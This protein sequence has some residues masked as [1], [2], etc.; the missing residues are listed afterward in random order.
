MSGVKYLVM[1][2]TN[3]NNKYYKMIPH[4]D[5]FTVEYGRLGQSSFQTASYPMSQFHKKYR[6]KVNKGYVDR[7]ELIAELV[8]EVKPETKDDEPQY[9]P[10]PNEIVAEIVKRLQDMAKKT[11]E[12]NYK[13]SS[14]MVTQKM[15]DESQWCLNQLAKAKTVEAFNKI[16]LENFSIISRRMGNVNDWL[17]TSKDEFEKIIEREQDLLDVMAGQVRQHDIDK[18]A[19][20]KKEK[21]SSDNKPVKKTTIMKAMGIDIK[22]ITKKEEAEI[23]KR[24]GSDAHRFVRA[25]RVKN[26]KTQKAFDEFIAAQ[27]EGFETKLL[28]HGS[29]NEN[30]WSIITT[31]LVLKPTNVVIS[32]K[33]FGYGIYFAPE[34]GKAIGYTSTRGAY[35]TSGTANTGF[36]SLYDIAYGKPYI[37]DKNYYSYTGLSSL[38]AK[39]L[40]EVAPGCNSLHAL[41]GVTGLRRD[42]VIVYN[43]NQATIKY[44]VE[45]SM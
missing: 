24:L 17:A 7:T 9:A 21:A 27:E 35:W 16:L 44:L 5:T 33:M 34:A 10:I 25:W 31:G 19:Q 32:G 29:R 41:K 1:V 45:V 22:P 20:Q 30:W 2:T 18:K 11:I 28:W 13:I 14:T 12:A 40:A 39:K 36:I 3:N 38:D 43:E 23:K 26:K 15:V 8:E 37:I 42:E 4:G 6:E